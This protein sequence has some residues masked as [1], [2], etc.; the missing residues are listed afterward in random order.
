MAWSAKHPTLDFSSGHDLTVREFEPRIRLCANNAEPARDSLSPSLS[1]PPLLALCIS[2]KINENK[3]K[4]KKTFHAKVRKKCLQRLS[5][6][7][8]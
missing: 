6:K 2:L 7:R 1:D 4:K 8:S 3:L 5:Q